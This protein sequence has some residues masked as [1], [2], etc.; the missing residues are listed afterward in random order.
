MLDPTGKD[1]ILYEFSGGVEGA[2]PGAGLTLD[3]TGNIYG[4]TGVGGNLRCNNGAGCGTVF[5]LIR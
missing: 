4:T 3:S 1:T 5:K 2:A